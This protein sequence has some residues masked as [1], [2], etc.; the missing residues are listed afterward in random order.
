MKYRDRRAALALL[1][2][3]LTVFWP[4]AIAF[5]YPGVMGTYWQ[6]RFHVGAGETGAVVTFMLV[7]LA[8]CMF[9][10]GQVHQR[11]GT[12]RCILIGT[13]LTA[14]AM[15]VLIRA[16]SMGAVYFWGF[17]SNC[18]CSFLFGPALT[19][20]QQWLPHRRGLASGLLNLTFG[21]SAAIMSPIW[22]AMLS[23][24]GYDAV[25]LSLLV[26]SVV[27]GLIALPLAE[28]PDRVKLPPEGA[29]AQQALLERS[30]VKGGAAG[31]AADYTVTQALRARTFWLIWLLWVFMGAA[32]ASMISLSKS[33]AISL[34]LSSVVVLTAFNITNGVGR[35]IAG[36]FCDRIGGETTGII[37]FV[38]AALGYLLL[39]HAGGE[40]VVAAL[41][42]CV[43]F[44]LGTL[45][46]VTGPIASQRFGLKHFGAIFGLIYTAYGFVG[47]VLGP[48]LSGVIL[49]RTG[50]S[51]TAVFTYLAGCALAGVLLMA[52]LRRTRS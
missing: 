45:F 34:G 7:G 28:G 13:G 12:R 4:G 27:T 3:C 52:L 20:A 43:G 33:Y 46:T 37:A 24:V 29:A 25:N 31:P 48:A 10:S 2:C 50:G 23:S 40:T 18:G 1:G 5:G 49:D 6:E 35:L 44:G 21:L 42:A 16:Q 9:F 38:L 19:T 41:S 39:P 36:I 15:L 32:G 8:A 51:Y 17:L 47:G 14:V 26:C 30:S 22:E 11:V